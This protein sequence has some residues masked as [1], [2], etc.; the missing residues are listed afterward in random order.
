VNRLLVLALVSLLTFGGCVYDPPPPYVAV[1][2]KYDRSFDAALSAAGD[3]GVEVRSVDRTTGRILGEKA[4]VE[5]T[6]ELQRQPDG[7]VRVEFNAPN[8]TETNPQL[9]ERWL[10]AYQRRMGR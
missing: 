5:V 7:M 6:I 1:P 9:G 8:S 2:S 3:V 4:G 10:S